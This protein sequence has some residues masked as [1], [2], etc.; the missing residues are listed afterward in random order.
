MH[1][2]RLFKVVTL[3]Y[4]PKELLFKS[5]TLLM[6][7]VRYNFDKQEEIEEFVLQFFIEK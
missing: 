6:K 1:C 3:T 4:H 5:A 7:M 2:S